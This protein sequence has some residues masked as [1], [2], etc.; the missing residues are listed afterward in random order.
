MRSRP[1]S[2][3][4]L[5]DAAKAVGLK[6][7]TYWQAVYIRHVV[8]EPKWRAGH[9]TYYDAQTLAEAIAMVQKLRGEGEL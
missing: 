2:A 9:R 7:T 3:I 4:T 1:P 8:P 5:G 6:Y